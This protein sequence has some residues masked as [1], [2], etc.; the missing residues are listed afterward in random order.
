MKR[1]SPKRLAIL[2]VLV[3]VGGLFAACGEQAGDTGSAA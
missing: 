1:N 2:A 3:T